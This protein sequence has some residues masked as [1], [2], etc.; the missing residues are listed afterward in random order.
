[1]TSTAHLAARTCWK[2]S[3]LIRPQSDPDDDPDDVDNLN[4][5]EE[6]EEDRG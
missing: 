6:D 3:T 2:A 5:E 4:S 1:M